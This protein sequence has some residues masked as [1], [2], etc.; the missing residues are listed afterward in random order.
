MLTAVHKFQTPDETN[1]IWGL[2]FAQLSI[3]ALR[4]SGGWLDLLL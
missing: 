3:Y 4:L 1:L 2:N